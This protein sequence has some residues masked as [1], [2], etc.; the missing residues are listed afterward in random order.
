[1]KHMY[2]ILIFILKI[3]SELI[4]SDLKKHF[5]WR[6]IVILS[7]ITSFKYSHENRF[8]LYTDYTDQLNY[9]VLFS[10][11]TVFLP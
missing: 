6:H 4:K 10:T 3:G 9:L 1:M 11:S 8:C 5:L 7:D 2:L